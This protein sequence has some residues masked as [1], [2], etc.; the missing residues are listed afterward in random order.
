MFSLYTGFQ[1][2]QGSILKGFAVY[3]TTYTNTSDKLNL[4]VIHSNELKINPMKRTSTA[5]SLL[6]AETQKA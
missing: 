6:K 4:T 1:F 3:Y 5:K 2:I